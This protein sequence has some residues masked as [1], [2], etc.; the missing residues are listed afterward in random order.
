M[1][2][3][4]NKMVIMHVHFMQTYKFSTKIQTQNFN[5]NFDVYEQCL[6][7]LWLNSGNMRKNRPHA[8]K[9]KS[10]ISTLII[11]LIYTYKAF[12]FNDFLL[13]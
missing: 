9:G 1:N 7:I 4:K 12:E 6:K 5:E 11:K 3:C 10:E 8:R 2:N 13:I